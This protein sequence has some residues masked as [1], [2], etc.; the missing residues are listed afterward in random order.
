VVSHT[1]PTLSEGKSR[2]HRDES[3][4][5][6]RTRT[7]DALKQEIYHISKQRLETLSISFVLWAAVDKAITTYGFAGTI[8]ERRKRGIENDGYVCGV[9]CVCI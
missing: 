1:Q 7:T 9:W 6:R 3:P 2:F 4:R 5:T 8:R